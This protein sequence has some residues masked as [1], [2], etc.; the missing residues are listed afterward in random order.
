VV[1]LVPGTKDDEDRLSI[2]KSLFQCS[3]S[4]LD[5]Y[6][7]VE[8]SRSYSDTGLGMLD[9]EFEHWRRKS[10]GPVLLSWQ[11]RSIPTLEDFCANR[12]T[13]NR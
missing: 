6:T 5:V 2:A 13:D 3:A 7:C 8:M 11:S 4:L 12:R 1:T 10:E 9:I